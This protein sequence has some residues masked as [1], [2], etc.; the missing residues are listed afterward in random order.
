M[1]CRR[2]S[3]LCAD[4][5]LL[6]WLILGDASITSLAVH[7]SIGTLL[8]GGTARGVLCTSLH[9]VNETVTGECLTPKEHVNAAPLLVVGIV[10]AALHIVSSWV[11]AIN[12]SPEG[13]E[14]RVS[15]EACAL[16]GERAL[17]V[18]FL[19][20][21]LTLTSVVTNATLI[22]ASNAHPSVGYVLQLTS[23]GALSSVC[24]SVAQHDA[25]H[26]MRASDL[27]YQWAHLLRGS[28]H[29]A[30]SGCVA[31]R[32]GTSI[33]VGQYSG[34]D[35]VFGVLPSIA[36]L[37]CAGNGGAGVALQLYTDGTPG[38]SRVLSG[39]GDDNSSK[40]TMLLHAALSGDGDAPLLLLTGVMGASHTRWSDAT[41]PFTIHGAWN[42]SCDSS[43]ILIAAVDTHSGTLL[44]WHALRLRGAKAVHLS[45]LAVLRE[46]GSHTKASVLVSVSTD[47]VADVVVDDWN[48]TQPAS[49]LATVNGSAALMLRFNPCEVSRDAPPL[50]CA[51]GRVL[52][53]PVRIV[54]G[55]EA[56]LLIRSDGTL[57]IFGEGALKLSA[58]AFI[59]GTSSMQL[60]ARARSHSGDAALSAPVTSMLLPL[61]V[62]CGD[63]VLDDGEECDAGTAMLTAA[64]VGCMQSCT[65]KAGWSCTDN[66]CCR[67]LLRSA[68][69]VMTGSD[70]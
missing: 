4:G 52:T 63:G 44:T 11:E 37:P 24:V 32:D 17:V 18:G 25:T 7:E 54:T 62:H 59:N 58:P 31:L 70:E 5:H 9:N 47:G 46:H 3:C 51:A 28:I 1:P 19:S 64:A 33:V 22:L 14:A 6:S 23:K 12:A 67:T 15:V 29:A 8:L 53:A 30:L 66:D 65:V 42:A 38:W 16:E 34:C 2:D 27:S 60:V 40:S 57:D 21:T 36:M 48:A 68:R 56:T 43:A 26:S 35:T 55:K 41:L 20:G 10:D 61:G 39:D 45:S 50:L 13:N 69:V 49:V